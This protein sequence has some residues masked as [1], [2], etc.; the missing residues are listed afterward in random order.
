VATLGA[1]RIFRAN[2]EGCSVPSR[3]VHAQRTSGTGLALDAPQRKPDVPI[4]TVSGWQEPQIR[5]KTTIFTGN[6]CNFGGYPDT[7]LCKP[8]KI[9]FAYAK[10]NESNGDAS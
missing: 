8:G 4:A 5:P 7:S 6:P 10:R 2:F 9:H 3:D 1:S